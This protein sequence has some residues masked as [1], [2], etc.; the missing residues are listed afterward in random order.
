MTNEN[1]ELLKTV[2]SLLDAVTTRAKHGIENT[3]LANYL[4]TISEVIKL[5][6]TEIAAIEDAI[7]G[8]MA[9][10]EATNDNN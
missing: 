3:P 10:K 5:V 2:N 9:E 1:E 6:I 7:D 4:D 8:F